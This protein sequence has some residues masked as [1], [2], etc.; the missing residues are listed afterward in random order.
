[1]KWL[2]RRGFVLCGER[3]RFILSTGGRRSDQ[4]GCCDEVW[5]NS[6]DP[7]LVIPFSVRVSHVILGH[8][9]QW[10][11]YRSCWSRVASFGVLIGKL[12]MHFKCYEDVC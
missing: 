7:N 4:R 6:D 5:S 3:F 2:K 9:N 1:M 10:Q 12:W 8:P 11:R